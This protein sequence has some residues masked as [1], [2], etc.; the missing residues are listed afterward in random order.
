MIKVMEEEATNG[1]FSMK[2]DHVFKELSDL[3]EAFSESWSLDNEL[4]E[5]LS[6]ALLSGG[7]LSGSRNITIEK[8][9]DDDV[10]VGE[11]VSKEAKNKE[12]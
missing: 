9:D 1:I 5:E 2:S 8:K 6:E 7:E 3:D 12:E 11:E 4:D 10:E